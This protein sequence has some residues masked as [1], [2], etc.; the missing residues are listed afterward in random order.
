MI[1]TNVLQIFVYNID[2]IKDRSNGR[3]RSSTLEKEKINFACREIEFHAFDF[4]D[5]FKRVLFHNFHSVG[6]QEK[7]RFMVVEQWYHSGVAIVPKI[8]SRR[9]SSCTWKGQAGNKVGAWHGPRSMIFPCIDIFSTRTT[10]DA[11]KCRLPGHENYIA[12]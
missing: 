4:Y 8:N 7:K 11:I 2:V 6:C 10:I 3:F 12:R 1:R 9:N 5:S